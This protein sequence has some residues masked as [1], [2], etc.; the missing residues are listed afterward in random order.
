M[1][2]CPLRKVVIIC[3]PVTHRDL[4]HPVRYRKDV[5]KVSVHDRQI[6]GAILQIAD[7]FIYGSN[8]PVSEHSAPLS[9]VQKIAKS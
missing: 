4:T 7:R 8:W 6:A 3:T 2:E 1:A 9:R 5:V